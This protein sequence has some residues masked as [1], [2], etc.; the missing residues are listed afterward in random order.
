MRYCENLIETWNRKLHYYIGLYLL[1]FIWLFSLSGLLLNHGSWK[2]A[3][4]WETRKQ[5]RYQKPLRPVAGTTD[6]ERA[7]DILAQLGLAG[8]I[9]LDKRKQQPGRIA[10]RAGGP[11][12]FYDIEADLAGGTASVHATTYNGWGAFR[13][14]H[15]SSGARAGQP[16]ERNWIMTRVWSFAMDAVAVGLAFMVLSGWWV[17]L[18][19]GRHRIAGTVS[20]AIGAAACVYLLMA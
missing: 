7:R 1:F 9:G 15:T 17:W 12:R 2:F 16:A 13:V 6:L 3:E 8:E 10:F 11:R 19:S 20:L 5:E 14:L 4:F 18:R